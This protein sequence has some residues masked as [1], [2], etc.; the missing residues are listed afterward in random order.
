MDIC[1]PTPRY[2]RDRPVIGAEGAMVAPMTVRLTNLRTGER[3][4]LTGR[5]PNVIGR[6]PLARV[7]LALGAVARRHTSVLR[8]DL[9]WEATDLGSSGGTWVRR[10]G[11]KASRI[12]TCILQSGDV[13]VYPGA[14]LQFLEDGEEDDPRISPK[15]MTRAMLRGRG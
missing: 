15:A 10:G 13:L 11:S 9:G 4:P 5:L 1:G 14:E 3:W 2:L 8:T 12:K 6:D 7:R